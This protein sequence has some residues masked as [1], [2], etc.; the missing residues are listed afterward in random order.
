MSDFSVGVLAEDDVAG[1]V[2]L[3]AEQEARLVA[4]DGRL[5]PPH[6]REQLDILVHLEELLE[7]ERQPE[8]TPFVVRADGVVRG[9]VQPGCWD[10]PADSTAACFLPAR[11]GLAYHLALPPPAAPDCALV[12]GALLDALDGRW[13]AL[14][15][16]GEVI[17]WP[18][19]DGWL[20]PLLTARGFLPESFLAFR[21]VTPLSSPKVA[22]IRARRAQPAD[23]DR[24][25][26]LYLE[27]IGFHVERATFPWRV[28]GLEAGFRVALAQAW[29]FASVEDHAPLLVVVER[30]GEVV[31][32][33]ETYIEQVKRGAGYLRP[34]RYG[35]LN[36]VAVREDCRGQ[37]VGRALAEAALAE[38]GALGVDGFYLYY[39][40]ANPLAQ[41]FW[42]RLGFEALVTR[43]QRRRCPPEPAGV[44]GARKV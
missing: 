39:M 1:V 42:P 18:S 15:T 20:A 22:D 36:N 12:A 19:R 4:L 37:G 31:G 2:E 35:Y 34:G 17:S 23:E 8:M 44:F 7:S 3:L 43:Y 28:E 11:V 38:L 27:E 6:G 29:A 32:M 41:G 14:G 40:A 33:A 9:Y 24:L 16:D 21:P 26:A 13:A 30:D 10:V 25:V 5:C